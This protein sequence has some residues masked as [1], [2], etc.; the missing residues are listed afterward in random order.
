MLEPDQ[1]RHE[2]TRLLAQWRAGDLQAPEALAPLIYD[3]LKAMAKRQ[4]GRETPGHTISATG[5]VHEAYLRLA[6]ADVSWRDRSHFYA[7]AARTMRRVLVDHARGANRERR[8]GGAAKVTLEDS[9]ALSHQGGEAI[10]M[11][12]ELLERLAQADANK[13][14]VIDLVYFGGL[15]QAETAEAMGISEQAVFRHLRLAKAW[16]YQAM[17]PA[18]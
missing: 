4:M 17:E 1:T 16:L 8:G 6:G 10:V 13:A 9:L 18:P 3:Q 12:N 7:V 15:T 2:V 14:T 11:L 5:L